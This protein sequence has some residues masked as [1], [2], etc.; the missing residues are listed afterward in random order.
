MQEVFLG[1]VHMMTY[2]HRQCVHE[3]F[4]FGK[5]TRVQ[6]QTNKQKKK[7][8]NKNKQKHINKQTHKQ[9]NK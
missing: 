6:K 3:N 7:Q 9:T 8:I 2:S 5:D 4:A 1:D